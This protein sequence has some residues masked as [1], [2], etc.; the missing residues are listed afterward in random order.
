MNAEELQL[1]VNEGLAPEI[2]HWVEQ[3]LFTLRKR[4]GARL[5]ALASKVSRAARDAGATFVIDGLRHDARSHALGALDALAAVADRAAERHDRNRQLEIFHHLNVREA[6]VAIGR[7]EP[8]SATPTFLLNQIPTLAEMPHVSR[9]LE[10]LTSAGLVLESPT[11]NDGRSRPVI[12]TSDAIAVLDENL[13]GWK[14]YGVYEDALES[15]RSDEE[16]VENAQ[17]PKALRV[18]RAEGRPGQGRR[19]L[20]VKVEGE[21]LPVATPV[22]VTGGRALRVIRKALDLPAT[23][24]AANK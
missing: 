21:I 12:L 2:E 24:G 15:A 7:A 10:K 6:L 9:L 17:T 20:Y 18:K 4:D 14:E 3:L 19:L 1:D 23:A 5:K 16:V 8:G 11:R 22:E 13:P